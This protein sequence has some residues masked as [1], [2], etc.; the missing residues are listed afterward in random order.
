MPKTKEKKFVLT[1]FIIA[2]LFYILLTYSHVGGYNLTLYLLGPT[3]LEP[4]EIYLRFL[5]I[6]IVVGFFLR[7]MFFKI[8]ITIL[9]AA[10]AVSVFLIF[11]SPV[12]CSAWAIPCDRIANTQLLAK[13]LFIL[14]VISTVVL[15]VAQIWRFRSLKS[16]NFEDDR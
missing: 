15:Y 12:Y 3:V 13:G 7:G 5:A 14:S 10:V 1:F 16:R 11:Q 8:W 2:L 4:L 9:S 6:S